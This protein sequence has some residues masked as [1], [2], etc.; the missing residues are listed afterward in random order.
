MSQD[1]CL[2]VL[3][4]EFLKLGSH[5][6]NRQNIKTNHILLRIF[7]YLFSKKTQIKVTYKN[8]GG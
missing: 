6:T 5:T 3:V 4:H 2:D 8:E 7:L 1:T